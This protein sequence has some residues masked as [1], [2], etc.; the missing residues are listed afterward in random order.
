MSR[1]LLSAATDGLVAPLTSQPLE[2]S[3]IR[4]AVHD[5][6]SAMAYVQTVLRLGYGPEGPASPRRR[7]ADVLDV[8]YRP[9]HAVPR[10]D[11]GTGSSTAAPDG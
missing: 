10:P 4:R 7:V 3:E 2:R 11:S 6:L 9:R 8:V 1:V 5:P